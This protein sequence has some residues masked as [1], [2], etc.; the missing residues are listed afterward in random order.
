MPLYFTDQ[1]RR[2]PPPKPIQY[3]LAIITLALAVAVLVGWL[4]LRFVYTDAEQGG[5]SSTTTTTGTSI[6]QTELPNTSYCLLIIEDAGHERFALMKI[7]PKENAITVDAISPS[8]P[9]NE[10]ETMAQL[11][12]RT[13]A[14]QLTQAVAAYYQL[15]LEHYVSLSIAELEKLIVTWGGSL[16]M[17]PAEEMS[18]RDENG[19]I[20]RLPAEINAM[21]PKQIAAM[22]RYNQW[23]DKQNHDGLA[24]DV[25]VAL[26]NQILTPNRD[27]NR[28]YSDLAAN[29]SLRIHHFNALY[30]GLKHLASLNDG[31]IA[32]RG[33]ILY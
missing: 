10:T 18:Y 17:A 19:A 16:R 22:L 32:Q 27:L 12:R 4:L 7:A 26:F 21:S 15:P 14:S 13:K 6:A 23:K 8:L 1:K 29:T 20:V 33:T 11:Y 28:C 25:A 3:V 30:E 2:W 9:L 5:G 31:A 24:A